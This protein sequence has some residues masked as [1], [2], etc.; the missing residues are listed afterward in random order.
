[1]DSAPTSVESA[2]GYDLACGLGSLTPHVGAAVAVGAAL[3]AYDP[4]EVLAAGEFLDFVSLRPDL[5]FDVG[6]LKGE[7]EKA[8][9]RAQ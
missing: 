6:Q 3:S 5:E 7:I 4:S 8:A 2:R 1:M 9:T